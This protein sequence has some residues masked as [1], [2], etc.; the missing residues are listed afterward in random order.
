MRSFVFILLAIA[1]MAGIASA[2][3][4]LGTVVS[5]LGL[6]FLAMISVVGL[7]VAAAGNNAP[8]RDDVS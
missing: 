5:T 6:A 3:M 4:F 8:H 1:L 2:T 7:V